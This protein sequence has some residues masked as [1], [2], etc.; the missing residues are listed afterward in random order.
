MPFIGHTA[1][2]CGKFK[3]L[4]VLSKGVPEK[5][6]EQLQVIQNTLFDLGGELCIPGST[7][8]VENDV[9][10]LE[11]LIDHYNENLP[12]LKDFILPG[13]GEV[14]S[15]CHLARTVARRAERI[16]VRLNGQENISQYVLAYV[17]R[18]SDLLFVL[19]RE[20]SR[21]QGRREVLWQRRSK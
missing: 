14:Q 2:S 16:L 5:M 18:L 4:I 20:L 15:F 3:H 21:Q 8:I 10:I 11:N 17:N 6:N 12:P 13:G 1:P 9:T 19:S 7:V